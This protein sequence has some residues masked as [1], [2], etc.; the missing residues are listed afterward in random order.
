MKKLLYLFICISLLFSACT[1]DS[2]DSIYDQTPDERVAERIKQYADALESAQNGWKT[3]YYPNDELYGAFSYVIKFHPETNE[4][5]MYSDLFAEG[6]STSTYRFQLQQEPSL[7]F[8]TFGQLHILSDPANG[9]KG[10]GYQGEFEFFF[11]ELSDDRIVLEGKIHGKELVLTKADANTPE[12]LKSNYTNSQLL[13]PQ[14]GMSFFRNLVLEGDINKKVSFQY[15]A[16]TRRVST[17]HIE[18]ESTLTQNKIGVE[19]TPNGF[20]LHTPLV[21]D[22]RSIQSFVYDEVTSSFKVSDDGITGEL[23]YDDAPPY[24]V[25]GIADD[26]LSGGFY[27]IDS[28]SNTLVPY[29]E[30]VKKD[31]P[32]FKGFQLYFQRSWILCYSNPA[33]DGTN[34]WSG[35]RNCVFTK[36]AEDKIFIDTSALDLAFSVWF[37]EVWQVNNGAKGLM[38]FLWDTDGFY[39][40]RESADE[41]YMVSVADPSKYILVGR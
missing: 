30:D 12:Q 37:Y 23:K 32:T 18:G 40:V 4:V 2:K 33:H 1:D 38:A 34:K 8:D 41:F 20:K 22:G 7:V 10:E 11:R 21:V 39:I 19:F 25:E 24:I 3:V 14:A 26:I 29:V 17:A 5:T 16:S 13:Q 6:S 28:Y 36:S 27:S 35:F 9:K 15:S 31:V